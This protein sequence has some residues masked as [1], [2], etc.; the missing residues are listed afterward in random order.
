MK[1]E[2]LGGLL[3]ALRAQLLEPK[4]TTEADLSTLLLGGARVRVSNFS[5]VLLSVGLFPHLLFPKPLH[6]QNK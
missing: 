1:R 4:S 6:F 5:E 3:A 2:A